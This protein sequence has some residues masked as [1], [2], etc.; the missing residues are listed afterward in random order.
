MAGEVIKTG[1]LQDNPT[2]ASV[3]V[4][5]SDIAGAYSVA[6]K[7]LLGEAYEIGRNVKK[8]NVS[9]DTE[10]E[11][12]RVRTEI[13]NERVNF[14]KKW[15][16]PLETQFMSDEWNENR[17]GAKKTLREKEL[18]ILKTSSLNDMYVS[19]E[20]DVNNRYHEEEDLNYDFKRSKT[21]RDYN[22]KTAEDNLGNYTYLAFNSQNSVEQKTFLD[23]LNASADM[24]RKNGVPETSINGTIIQTFNQRVREDLIKNTQRVLKTANA[25][26]W[27]QKV[28]EAEAYKNH[29]IQKSMAMLGS[30]DSFKKEDAKALFSATVEDNISVV[31]KM[32]IDKKENIDYRQAIM[33]EKEQTKQEKK[34]EE[35]VKYF[36]KDRNLADAG[37]VDDLI[38]HRTNTPANPNAYYV[39]YDMGQKLFGDDYNYLAGKVVY[40]TP[41]EPKI[42]SLDAIGNGEGYETPYLLSGLPLKNYQEGIKQLKDNKASNKEI[43]DFTDEY[44]KSLA[45]PT[46]YGIEKDSEKYNAIIEGASITALNQVGLDPKRFTGDTAVKSVL[47]NDFKELTKN[48][49][50]DKS[51][52]EKYI[53][54][55]KPYLTGEKKYK[56]KFGLGENKEKYAQKIKNKLIQINGGRNSPKIEATTVKYMLSKANTMEEEFLKY[57]TAEEDLDTVAKDL[58]HLT[59]SSGVFEDD[60]QLT[61]ELKALWEMEIRG[62]QYRKAPI[63]KLTLENE[64]GGTNE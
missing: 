37:N 59:S 1:A 50:Y 11:L 51:Q 17:N 31:D 61:R 7:R 53:T 34:R 38:S 64:T 46:E 58:M 24:L 45:D 32:L 49:Y 15:D 60:Q 54:A 19:K 3:Q 23:S 27:E 36:D 6:Y 9:V 42:I 55:M 30:L 52:E 39:S 40:G 35:V 2:T 43:K 13:L 41:Q 22:L 21:I 44:I 25:S 29:T 8:I 62:V 16:D 5:G 18:E 56:T 10:K 14:S 63:K 28:A 47:D 20:E 12:M 33:Y 48:R 4:S 57:N 26:N